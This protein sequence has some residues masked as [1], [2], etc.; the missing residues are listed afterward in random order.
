MA[1]VLTICLS[2]GFQRT[3]K[4]KKLN[5]GDVNRIQEL[6]FS[7]SGKGI[8]ISRA[9]TEKGVDNI[10]LCH[11]GRSS[12]KEFLR[13]AKEEGLK[14]ASILTKRHIRTCSTILEDDGTTTEIVE[15][16]IKVSKTTC[17]RLF[18]KFKRLVK[19]CEIVAISGSK[20]K[21]YPSWI[22]PKMVEISKKLGKAV[23]LDIVGDDLSNSIR[24]KPDYI[25]IN[26]EEMINTFNESFIE[27]S[28]KLIKDG[29]KLIVTGGSG[30]ILYLKNNRE[31]KYQPRINP[32][33]INTTG[34]GD[35]FTA[36]LISSIIK[37][38]GI[39][40]VIKRGSELGYL[41]TLTPIPGSIK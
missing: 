8:N 21:G 10:C 16:S 26:R 2:P 35:A 5:I 37:N 18:T 17:F 19:K 34:C 14:L 12:K 20:S 22:I 13:E 9:L 15:E 6:Y 32:S 33:P 11:L 38:R 28:K 39:E 24:F 29:I 31:I 3:M 36:G 30:E 40:E 41:N 1:R 7:I 27:V 23:V 4:L 25:K